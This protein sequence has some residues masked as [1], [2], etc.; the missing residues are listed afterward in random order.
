MWYYEWQEQPFGPVSKETVSDALRSGKINQNTL[1]W[2]EGMPDWK[3]LI[4]TEL[5]VL[6]GISLPTTA[7]DLSFPSA[8]A[9]TVGVFS[10]GA[11][12]APRVNPQGLK[13]LFGWWL[14][15]TLISLPGLFVTNFLSDDSWVMSLVCIFYIPVLAGAV[16]QYILT[17]RF[18]QVIQDGEQR[19]TPGRA[20][21]FLFIPLF[22]LYWFFVAYFGLATDIN[23]YI[24][25][26]F[27]SKPTLSI[28]E[29][30]PWLSICYVVVYW[31]AVINQTI[32]YYQSFSG[33]VNSMA[34]QSVIGGTTESGR[35]FTLV[36]GVIQVVITILVFIDY[37]RSTLAIREAEELSGK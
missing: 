7:Q 26:H 16:L 37:Y 18:W 27:S 12:G 13:R 36:L 24:S 25:R 20:V 22:N 33:V 10:R 9:S 21:G 15:L 35:I 32:L 1:V 8:S 4:E 11:K 17:Y 30:H 14:G 19:T 28:P 6:L 31:I 3:P 34:T 29:T 2:H 5:A 23:R